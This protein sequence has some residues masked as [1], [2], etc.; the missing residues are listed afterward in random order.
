MFEHVNIDLGYD[1]IEAHTT[2][3]G[4]RY[5]APN[6]KTYPSITTVL[7]ILSEDSIRAWR[8]KVGEEAANRKSYRASQRGEKVHLLCERYIDNEPDYKEGF[9]PDIL[10]TFLSMKPI[11]DSRIGKVYAQEVPLYSAHFG[12]AGRV[13]L[14]AEFDGQLSIIDFKTSTKP[15]KAEWIT[16]YF[17]QESFYAVAWE[18]ITGKPITQ[19]VTIIGVDHNDPQVFVEHRDTWAPKLQEVINEYKS[20]VDAVHLTEGGPTH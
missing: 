15:K 5:F 3:Q 7:S 20:R 11:F 17:M 6:G 14:V 9:T 12:V 16:S 1:D 13:D 19:L 10:A 2:P 18:E 8:E 4:R